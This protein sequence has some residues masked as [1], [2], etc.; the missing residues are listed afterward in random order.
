MSR[1]MDWRKAQLYG[2]RTLDYRHELDVP[3][4]AAKWLRAVEHRLQQQRITVTSSS[5]AIARSTR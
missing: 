5:L 2:R 1:R 3:D 4:R